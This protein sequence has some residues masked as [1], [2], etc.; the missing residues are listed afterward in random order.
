MKSVTTYNNQQLID[1]AMQE[2]GD[3]ERVYELCQLN[4]FPLTH[5]LEAGAILLVPDFEA[6]KRRRVK[7][8]SNGSLF[9]ASGDDDPYM[10]LPP[11]GIGF[12]QI[13]NTFITS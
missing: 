3:V 10:I 5:E 11:G 8:F 7:T 1:I 2:L 13:G 9:P 6:D 4:D 12:M